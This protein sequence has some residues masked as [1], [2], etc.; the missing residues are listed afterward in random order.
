MAKGFQVET[1]DINCP[2]LGSDIPV[3]IL[4]PASYYWDDEVYTEL[5]VMDSRP[6]ETIVGLVSGFVGG[7]DAVLPMIMIRIPADIKPGPEA[8]S[9]DNGIL[10][11]DFL[12]ESVYPYVEKKYRTRPFRVLAGDQLDTA[13]ALAI[14]KQY[15]G[16]F[17]GM[18]STGLSETT[19]SEADVA[20]AVAANAE[21]ANTSLSLFLV[22]RDKPTDLAPFSSV[23]KEL[24]TGNEMNV[25]LVVFDGEVSQGKRD[26]GV[27]FYKGLAFCYADW[28]VRADLSSITPDDLIDH[29]RQLSDR[30]GVEIP[31]SQRIVDRQGRELLQAGK[32]V[33]GMEAL[34]YNARLHPDS[35]SARAAV[36]LALFG[37]ARFRLAVMNFKDAVAIG[38]RT[39]HPAL[40][41]YQEYLKTAYQEMNFTKQET[42]N[43]MQSTHVK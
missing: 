11:A 36:G 13:T 10:L 34:R 2:A 27:L 29:Y 35:A 23:E 42:N 32:Y 15:P 19:V 33:H 18:V 37:N 3:E 24:R 41:Q 43:A 31:A 28:Q 20:A 26:Q 7:H 40:V 5:V 8:G 9:S 39:N 14:S 17:Q 4:V 30:I 21:G 1:V 38:E 16:L 12:V 25:R 6:N 22:A